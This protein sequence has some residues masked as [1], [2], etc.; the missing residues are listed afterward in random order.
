MH[1]KTWRNPLV[2]GDQPALI[3]FTFFSF[4]V[5]EDDT[6]PTDRV[7]TPTRMHSPGCCERPLLLHS[8]NFFS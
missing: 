1:S 4:L 2:P 5:E 8:Q 6:S 7:T 3:F